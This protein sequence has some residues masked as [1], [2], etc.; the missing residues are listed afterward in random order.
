MEQAL[1]N[2]RVVIFDVYTTLLEVGPPPSNGDALWHRLFEEKLGQPPPLSR[3]QFSARTAQAIARLHAEARARGIPWPEILWPAVVLEV[4]PELA[5][6][7]APELEDFLVRQMQI[8]RTLR[9]ADGAAK[10]LRRLNENHCLLGIASNSQAYTLRELHNALQGAGLNLSL[11]DREL[12]FW[13]FEHGFSKPDP[14][15]FRILSAR[16][17]ARGISARET[18]MVGDRLDNDIEPA[19]ARGWQ[20]WHLQSGSALGGGFR[21]LGAALA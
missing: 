4:I 2:V 11:F 20:V 17:E 8:G 19:R 15:V 21:E 18:L 14:H 10:C 1:M 3:T 6:L 5:R 9:L 12:C 7:R 13:S 16:L